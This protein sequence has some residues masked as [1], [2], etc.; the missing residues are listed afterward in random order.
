MSCWLFRPSRRLPANVLKVAKENGCQVE[1]LEY[2]DELPHYNKVKIKNIPSL[3]TVL[4][5]YIITKEIWSK[6]SIWCFRCKFDTECSSDS[7]ENSV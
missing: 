1:F 3:F 2:F 7:L 4:V 6:H 5:D